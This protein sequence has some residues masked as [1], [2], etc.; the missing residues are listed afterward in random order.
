MHNLGLLAE[1]PLPLYH[2]FPAFCHLTSAMN[3]T[4]DD[5]TLHAPPSTSRILT[6]RDTVLELNR[7]KGIMN[8]KKTEW[9]T[10]A[11]NL[12]S[13]FIPKSFNPEH[14]L[15]TAMSNIYKF[16][17]ELATPHDS[18]SDY[19]QKYD[20]FTKAQNALTSADDR[21][22]LGIDKRNV[23]FTVFAHIA[24]RAGNSIVDFG[25]CR[26]ISMA[27]FEVSYRGP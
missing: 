19:V 10:R 22:Q 1:Y 17:G 14:Q 12:R 27:Y 2:H 21:D 9:D 7:L 8:A 5:F 4:F 3:T 15:A 11:T 20:K 18:D 26:T 13:R 16:L 23:V 6:N 24:T 25:P